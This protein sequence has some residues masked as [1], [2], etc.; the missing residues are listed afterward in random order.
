MLERALTK[1]SHQLKARW[2]WALSFR[3]HEWKFD[4]YPF[5]VRYQKPDPDSPYEN[6]PRFKQPRYI[7]SLIN[8]IVDGSGDATEEATGALRANFEAR[9]ARFIEEGRTIPRPGVHVPIE[10]ASQEQI[11]AQGELADDFIHRVLG[12]DWAIVTD[13]S[14]LWDFHTDTN[15]ETLYAKIREVYGVDVSDIE[16]ALVCEILDRIAGARQNAH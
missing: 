5:F 7:A 10:I 6:N 2:K 15:N 14:S 3:S 12:L 9:R 8:W 16:S 11:S 4:D 1:V 13:K